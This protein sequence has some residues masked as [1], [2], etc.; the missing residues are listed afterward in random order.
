MSNRPMEQNI[1]P[2]HAPK[3]IQNN[4]YDLPNHQNQE[5]DH[6]VSN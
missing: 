3:E 4:K 6:F 2:I 5:G 1:R